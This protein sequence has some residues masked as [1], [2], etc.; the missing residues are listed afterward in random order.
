MIYNVVLISAIQQSDSVIHIHTL[1][2]FNIFS[3]VVYHRLFFFNLFLAVLGLRCC[4]RAFSSCGERGATL[5]WGAQASHC[6]GFSW[7][8]AWALGVR[9]SVVVAHGFSSCGLRALEPQAQQLWCTGLVA[10]RHLGSSRTKARTH[11]PCVGRWILNHC[12]TREALSYYHRLL[13]IV[14][15]A[16]Q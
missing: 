5:R 10:P 9:A 2:F 16:I 12:A 4:T 11:V 14:V 13:N 7:C 8:G 6:S 1:F 15:C 3:M